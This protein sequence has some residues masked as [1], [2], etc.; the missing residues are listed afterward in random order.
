MTI[1]LGNASEYQERIQFTLGETVT[2]APTV[3]DLYDMLEISPETNL[4]IIGSE[5]AL[6]QAVEIAEK[7]RVVRPA[8]GVV[9]IR[10]RLDVSILNDAIRAGIRE[11]VGEDDAAALLGACARSRAISQRMDVALPESQVKGSQGHGK[12]V[13][14]F[15]AKG[16]CGKTTLSVNLADAL[17]MAEGSKVCLVDFDLQFGDVAVA[18]QIEPT[19]NISQALGM[20]KNLDKLGVMSLLI[21]YKDKFDVLLAPNNP[22]DVE[23]ISADLAEII[24]NRLVET[25]D[26]VVVDSPPA[27][28][29]VILKS[30]DMADYCL[31]LTTLDMPAL[32]N[33]KVSMSTLKAIG[34]PE[35][36]S[37]VVINRSDARSGLT[38]SD[39]EDSIGTK[40]AALIP[41]SADVP[42]TIN[43][44]ET[45]TT[46]MPR[47]KVSKAIFDIADLVRENSG[48]VQKGETR[49]FLRRS[50]R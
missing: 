45:I 24:L 15:S 10:K 48:G 20:Q 36:K 22:T 39:V 37:Q 49:R 35:S 28:T 3:R 9:L 1:F 14:V 32:K 21:S 46:S 6:T 26:Y 25:Y 13:L 11:V 12:I 18:L 43:R 23:H 41:T 8:L 17:S 30:F 40:V 2:V 29:E 31:L 47:H 34:I 33:L 5:S 38:I 42:L 4:I 50:F 19:K 27:F 7:Y 44:G 16:G